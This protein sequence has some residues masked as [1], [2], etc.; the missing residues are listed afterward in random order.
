M[1]GKNWRKTDEYR[2][3]LFNGAQILSMSVT[4]FGVPFVIGMVKYG[5]YAT[6]FA[7]PATLSVF[8]QGLYVS[9][10][11]RCGYAE[12]RSGAGLLNLVFSLLA[13]SIG[14]IFGHLDGILMAVLLAF[15]LERVRWETLALTQG[16]NCYANTL[17]DCELIAVV[18]TSLGLAVAYSFK[19]QSCLLPVGLICGNL[20]IS[21]IKLIR[22]CPKDCSRSHLANAQRILSGGFSGVFIRIHE[23]LF[24]SQMPYTLSFVLGP[25][26]VGIFRV[27]I[28]VAK[29]FFKVFP[30]RYEV[31][32]AGHLQRAPEAPRI[33]R[34]FLLVNLLAIA[35]AIAAGTANLAFPALEISGAVDIWILSS[36]GCLALT[37]SFSPLL[38]LCRPSYYALVIAGFLVT[39]GLLLVRGYGSFQLS[40]VGMNTLFA[41]L[42]LRFLC[43]AKRRHSGLDV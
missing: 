31:V 43:E 10:L 21:I 12:F 23:E 40:F 4:S 14:S 26:E 19:F 8:V 27:T 7:L 36:A 2:T 17:R 16:H 30:Y 37:S 18:V 5:E 15:L 24:I 35:V 9:S 38:L 34:Y 22:V 39:S 25:R 42:I 20:L 32:I 28:S 33:L 11:K 1:F 6:L 3:S 41:C 29:F 13:L